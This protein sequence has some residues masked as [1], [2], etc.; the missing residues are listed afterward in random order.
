MC[1][2]TQAHE[3]RRHARYRIMI[4]SWK[5]CRVSCSDLLAQAD[6]TPSC[7]TWDWLAINANA[8]AAA[9][10]AIRSCGQARHARRHT[11]SL[12]ARTLTMSRNRQ[13]PVPE[14]MS[15]AFTPPR[16]SVR[17]MWASTSFS[18]ASAT[19]HVTCRWDEHK[20]WQVTVTA[21]DTRAVRLEA[22]SSRRQHEGRTVIAWKHLTY[23]DTS[24]CPGCPT[25]S[26]RP[27]RNYVGK[28]R[29]MQH[30]IYSPI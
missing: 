1:A 29:K 4:G 11:S 15:R 6:C 22:K 18:T 19:P 23:A 30:H 9:R 10:R 27:H 20:S 14:V 3:G 5:A 28:M 25:C 7:S 16:L 26:R 24:V 8:N 17:R 2:A 21:P 12:P 13:S